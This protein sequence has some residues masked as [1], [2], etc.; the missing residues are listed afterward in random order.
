MAKIGLQ[1]GEKNPNF[2]KMMSQDVKDK[3]SESK[4]SAVS[5]LDLLTNEATVYSSGNKAA[6]AISCPTSTFKVYLRSGKVLKNRYILSKV[7]S[8]Q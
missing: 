3:I 1:V 7:I 2:G 8:K 5:I 4:G 6:G